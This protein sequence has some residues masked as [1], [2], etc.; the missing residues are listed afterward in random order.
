MSL[1]AGTIQTTIKSALDATYGPPT[2]ATAIAE[3]AKFTQA[4]ANALVTVLTSQMV[5][6]TTDPISGPLIAVVS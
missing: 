6:T 4:L 3:Q 1:S 2:G 5:V